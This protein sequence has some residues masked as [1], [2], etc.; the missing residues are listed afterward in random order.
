MVRVAA[1]L[2]SVALLVVAGCGDGKSAEE[3]EAVVIETDEGRVRISVE[4]ADSAK[5]RER[6][7]MHRESLPEN[8][9]MLFVYG[10]ETTGGFWMKNTRI[11]L[12]VAFYDGKGRI[13]RILDMEPCPAEPCPVYDPGVVYR[14]ALEVN[15]GAFERWGVSEGDVIRIVG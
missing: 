11:P 14:G 4:I 3:K 1:A 13:I 6:G 2:F 8:A 5:E 9:G 7:L 10:R 15:Q 12:S